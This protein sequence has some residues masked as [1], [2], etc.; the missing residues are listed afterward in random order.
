[1]TLPGAYLLSK[2]RNTRTLLVMRSKTQVRERWVISKVGSMDIIECGLRASALDSS[3]I[4][5]GV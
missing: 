1:M 5:F 2:L 4:R 3:P